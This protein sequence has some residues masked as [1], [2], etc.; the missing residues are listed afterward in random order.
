[1]AKASLYLRLFWAPTVATECQISYWQ[2]RYE[3]CGQESSDNPSRSSS[4]SSHMRTSLCRAC[5]YSPSL[6]PA[7]SCELVVRQASALNFAHRRQ[8]FPL[9]IGLGLRH[10]HLTRVALTRLAQPL[11]V[12]RL[13][14]SHDSHLAPGRHV[15]NP[16]H[17][18]YFCQQVTSNKEDGFQLRRYSLTAII[19]CL[20]LVEGS[21]DTR[22]NI[23]ILTATSICMQVLPLFTLCTMRRNLGSA[24]CYQR[25]RLFYLPI[26]VLASSLQS[27][28]AVSSFS[29]SLVASKRFPNRTAHHCR[30]RASIPGSSWY[31]DDVQRSAC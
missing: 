17:S 28:S 4:R 12:T 24:L 25:Q 26:W 16:T 23:A 19:S 15:E 5:Q 13:P 11:S 20:S 21:L 31:R 3:L 2:R 27:R 30:K 8:H 9:M 14:S 18:S 10:A 6:V 29:L 7:A 1:M 22:W